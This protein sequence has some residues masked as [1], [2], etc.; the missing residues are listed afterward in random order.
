[1]KIVFQNISSQVVISSAEHHPL[2]QLVRSQHASSWFCRA[3]VLWDPANDSWIR[4]WQEDTQREMKEE[5]GSRIDWASNLVM[6]EI[7]SRPIDL[8]PYL[9]TSCSSNGSDGSRGSSCIRCPATRTCSN[10]SSTH[11]MMM[12]SIVLWFHVHESRRH[13]SIHIFEVDNCVPLVHP[14]KVWRQPSASIGSGQGLLMFA[15]N[16]GGVPRDT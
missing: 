16:I 14:N 7:A 15:K 13:L 12:M 4:S 9:L 8:P 11:P 6:E 10:D 1:M 3:N 2:S 5:E